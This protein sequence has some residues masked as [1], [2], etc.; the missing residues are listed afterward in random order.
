MTTIND[1]L[2]VLTK[3]VNTQ[4]QHKEAN[5]KSLLDLGFEPVTSGTAVRCVYPKAIKAT[6][7]EQYS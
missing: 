7:K 3:Q 2:Y 4:Q 6:D 1:K 5:L